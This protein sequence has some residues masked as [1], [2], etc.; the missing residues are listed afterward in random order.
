MPDSVSIKVETNQPA[1]MRDGATLH[2]DVY[3]PDG[4]GRFQPS[5][6]GHP[7]TRHRHWRR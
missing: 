5:S 7:T 4:P 6:S 2:A 3:W 1:A